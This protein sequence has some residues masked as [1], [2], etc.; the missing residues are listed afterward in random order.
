MNA[1]ESTERL[2]QTHAWHSERRGVAEET[3]NASDRAGGTTH[4]SVK[5]SA[6]AQTFHN[7]TNDAEHSVY[8]MHKGNAERIQQHTQRNRTDG[9]H[10]H[11]TH[12]HT[13]TRSVYRKIRQLT[14]FTSYMR[15]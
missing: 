13:H 14:R 1:T 6:Q 2:T 3:G 9:R 12:T 11:S 7:R 4:E 5:P 8:G 15:F 10:T